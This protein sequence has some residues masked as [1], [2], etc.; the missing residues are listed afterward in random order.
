VTLPYRTVDGTAT[1]G[2]DYTARA[3][4]L[5]VGAGDRSGTISVPTR[6]D[7]DAA[8]GDE[9]VSLTFGTAVNARGPGRA[10]TGTIR[11]GPALGTPEISVSDAAGVREG[12]ALSFTVT[13]DP[14]PA[15]AVTVQYRTVDGTATAGADYTANFGRVTFAAGDTSKTVAV[16]TIDDG[17]NE[18]DETLRLELARVVSGGAVI[19]DGDGV[20]T[21]IGEKAT[22]SVHDATV[23]EEDDSSRDEEVLGGH[24]TVRLDRALEVDLPFGLAFRSDTALLGYRGAGHNPFSDFFTRCLSTVPAGETLYRCEIV[25]QDDG[26]YEGTETAEIVLTLSSARICDKLD[27]QDCVVPADHAVIGDGTA[28]LSITED[29]APPAIKAIDATVD[30]GSTLTLDLR[31]EGNNSD[32]TITLDWATENGAGAGAATAPRHYVA[33]SGTVTFLPAD[34]VNPDGVR[35]QAIRIKTRPNSARDGDKVFYVRLSRPHH[36]TL[37]GDTDNDGE[38]LVKITIDDD[39]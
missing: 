3:A 19:G 28:T 38:V 21:I 18:V 29:E 5:V 2:A 1:A 32:R 22:I 16:A 31:L 10:A 25:T 17:V 20:G 24:L 12:A 33:G 23:D 35:L 34:D 9:T 36:A 30:E 7:P 4:S 37:W 14:A 8:E 15:S 39:D 26:R 11:D 27:R 13:A 6:R